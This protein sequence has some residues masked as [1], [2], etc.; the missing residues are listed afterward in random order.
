MRFNGGRVAVPPATGRG[1]DGCRHKKLKDQHPET[2]SV[3]L[4][5]PEQLLGRFPL[6]LGGEYSRLATGQ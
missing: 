4:G 2:E 5:E 6:Q 3:L 1:K